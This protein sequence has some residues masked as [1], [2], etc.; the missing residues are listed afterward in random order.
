MA[1]T[2]YVEIVAPA[3]SAFRGEAS[4]FRAPGAEGSFEVL[5]NH[6]PLIAATDI[7]TTVITDPEGRRVVFATGEGF[8][9][10]L[11]NRVIMVVESADAAS[12]IDVDRARAAEDAARQRLLEGLSPEER[13]EAE[14]EM[15][16]A[17]NRLRAAMARV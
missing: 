1:K 4:R 2:L 12:E 7:G 8:V 3:G 6:A 15:E 11:D 5:Y 17:R 9:E 13:A 16:M 10:V 14:A